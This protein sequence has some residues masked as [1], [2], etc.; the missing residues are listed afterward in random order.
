[1]VE[2]IRIDPDITTVV[3]RKYESGD[4]FTGNYQCGALRANTRYTLHYKRPSWIT[5]YEYQFPVTRESPG[6]NSFY[7]LSRSDM[8]TQVTAVHIR[9]GV[10][11]AACRVHHLHAKGLILMLCCKVGDLAGAHKDLAKLL[12]PALDNWRSVDSCVGY[13]GVWNSANDHLIKKIEGHE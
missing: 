8:N 5:L 1:M 7:L 11:N 12:K 6:P 4:L 13:A 10:L 9:G 2:R 3:S